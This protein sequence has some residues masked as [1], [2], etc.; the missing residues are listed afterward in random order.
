M[1]HTLCAW[2]ASACA[3]DG[4]ARTVV[5]EGATVGALARAGVGGGGPFV[6]GLGPEAGAG[7]GCELCPDP[8]HAECPNQTAAPIT[9]P[10][11]A[12]MAAITDVLRHVCGS[13]SIGSVS[14]DHASTVTGSGVDDDINVSSVAADPASVGA[15]S[16][17]PLVSGSGPASEE[18]DGGGADGVGS[19]MFAVFH[20]SRRPKPSSY[21][22]GGF[23]MVIWLSDNENRQ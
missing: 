1:A 16:T 17:R 11:S 15:Q 9:M 7:A 2:W 21:S 6:V 12:R 5:A 22:G 8:G 23:A 20:C 18:P 13:R 14:S 3:V 10:A 19:L 4:D